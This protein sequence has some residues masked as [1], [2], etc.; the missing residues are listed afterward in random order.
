M[1]DPS[2]PLPQSLALAVKG[3]ILWEGGWGGGFQ[4]GYSTE[5]HFPF[6]A[7]QAVRS[8][9]TESNKCLAQS[10]DES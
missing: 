3:E 1:L 7:F 4:L 2:Y 9:Q 5:H 6:A 8:Q 10:R